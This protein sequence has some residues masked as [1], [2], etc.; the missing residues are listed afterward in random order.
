MRDI[1]ND[2]ITRFLIARFQLSTIDDS[3]SS[4]SSMEGGV[5]QVSNLDPLLYVVIKNDLCNSSRFLKHSM[6]TD[7]TSLLY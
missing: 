2:W 5:P 7:D 6:Y 3:F 4:V 1:G